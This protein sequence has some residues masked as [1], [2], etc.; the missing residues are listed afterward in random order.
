MTLK[1]KR[2][3]PDAHIPGRA[4]PGSAG[5]DLRACCVGA[6]GLTLEPME[7]ALVPTGIAV[8]LP[9]P[10]T[11]ALIF[12]RSGLALR[13]GLAMA[14]GV[15]VIDSD[16]R[17]EVQVPVVNLSDKPVYISNGERIAQMLV[18]PVTVPE[19]IEFENLSDTERGEGGFG[20]TGEL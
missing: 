9:G 3:R 14:N 2:L 7:R 16:Y 1:I 4:T 11:V 18:M 13:S 15:G 5:V 8:E 10:D 6:R 20:S 19:M 17:G 12:A